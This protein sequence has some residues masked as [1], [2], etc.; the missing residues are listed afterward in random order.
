MYLSLYPQSPAQYTHSILNRN[1]SLKVICTLKIKAL[2]KFELLH[3]IKVC[4][5][6]FPLGF[7][8]SGFISRKHLNDKVGFSPIT[9]YQNT[10]ELTILIVP[11]CVIISKP[12]YHPSI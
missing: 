11:C 5:D 1:I 10:L 3:I 12:F 2:N 9:V 7:Y 4:G 6:F 8:L